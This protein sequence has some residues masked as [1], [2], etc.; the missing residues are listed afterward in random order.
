M[1]EKKTAGVID[2][3]EELSDA[4]P[5]KKF[6]QRIKE[7]IAEKGHKVADWTRDNAE[8]LKVMAPIVI[9][10]AG[11]T[12]K[13]VYKIASKDRA[14]REKALKELY[15]YD[16]SLGHYWKLSR[17][18]KSDEWLEVNQRRKAGESLGAIFSDMDVL[19]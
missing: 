12:V 4:E 9:A 14:K 7:S 18:L 1:D 10:V 5:K 13:I 17:V 2:I 3:T 6:A 16:R 15:C 8:M 19:K 11:G